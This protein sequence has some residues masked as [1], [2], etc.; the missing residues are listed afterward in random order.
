[1]SYMS[2]LAQRWAGCVL[3][4]VTQ[5]ANF[6]QRWW[7]YLR[8][9]KADLTGNAVGFGMDLDS[10]IGHGLSSRDTHCQNANG[11]REMCF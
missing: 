1:M 8:P 9:T 2:L 3:K 10:G 7:G 4:N 6:R 11:T 5:S